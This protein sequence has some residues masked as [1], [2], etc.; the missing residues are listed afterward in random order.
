MTE[1]RHERGF[2]VVEWSRGVKR[3]IGNEMAAGTFRPL[4]LEELSRELGIPLRTDPRRKQ[5][6]PSTPAFERR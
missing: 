1:T 3:E 5:R 4:S 2:D 6:R